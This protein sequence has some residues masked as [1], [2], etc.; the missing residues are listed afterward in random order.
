[1]MKT[2]ANR[3]KILLKNLVG[4]NQASFIPG[5][6]SLDNVIVCQ[7]IV[8]SLRYTTAKKGGDPKD[9]STEGL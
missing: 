3:L 9:R 2:I 4:P 5:R 8:H 1:M 6:Q 7:E